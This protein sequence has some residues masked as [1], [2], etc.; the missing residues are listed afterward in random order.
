MSFYSYT[1][2]IVL[3]TAIVRIVVP[4]GAR[5]VVVSFE[6]AAGNVNRKDP[7]RTAFGEKFLLDNNFAVVGILPH[8]KSWYRTPDVHR[9]LESSDLRN[10][11]KTFERIH[12]YGASMGGYG[13]C[14]FAHTLGAHNVIALQPVSTLS[15]AIVPWE[16]RFRPGVQFDWTGPYKDAADGLAGIESIWFIYDPDC[17]D[18]RHVVRLSEAA[19]P[20]T[21]E[22]FVHNCGHAAAYRLRQWDVLKPVALACLQGATQAEV[23]RI[24]DESNVCD[25]PVRPRRPVSPKEG[26]D[27]NRNEKMEQRASEKSDK[28]AI[29]KT[30]PGVTANQLKEDAVLTH[31]ELM[32]KVKQR[33][34]DKF[35]N[36]LVQKSADWVV[37]EFIQVIADELDNTGEV[38]IPKL[39]V[40][41]TVERPAKPGAGT[42]SVGKGETIKVIRF[43]R[44]R[45]SNKGNEAGEDRD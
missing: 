5:E 2:L 22:V 26:Q 37:N 10:F 7:L 25:A 27:L 6:S 40:F 43:T 3:E 38:T 33:V 24:I 36:P 23:Q 16:W 45:A 4:E 29:R 8:E 9:F 12:T 41:K 17:D 28:P 20:A 21:R 42:E 11:L 18:K 14:A 39:G 15:S 19:G 30:G 44:A 31:K 35:K 13:A 1:N 32:I 34:S